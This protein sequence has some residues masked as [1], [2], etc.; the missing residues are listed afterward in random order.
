MV[1][2]PRDEGWTKTVHWQPKTNQL[3]EDARNVI[4]KW[5][6]TKVHSIAVLGK[7][8]R[9]QVLAANL[10]SPQLHVLSAVTRDSVWRECPSYVVMA[11]TVTVR[12]FWRFGLNYIRNVL[13]SLSYQEEVLF[14]FFAPRFGNSLG[15]CESRYCDT[16]LGRSKKHPFPWKESHRAYN[17]RAGGTVINIVSNYV[18][19]IHFT[20]NPKTYQFQIPPC[21]LTIYMLHKYTLPVW[22]TWPF[23]SKFKKYILTTF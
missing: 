17:I 12:T 7:A 2:G 5:S 15:L 8:G 9:R 1:V 13:W 10:S 3:V 14:R 4:A 16:N 6:C 23:H 18:S 20:L 19:R 21:S 11:V 22:R